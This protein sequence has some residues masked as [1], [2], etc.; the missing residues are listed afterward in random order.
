MGNYLGP[1]IRHAK[2]DTT[3]VMANRAEQ[4][5]QGHGQNAAHIGGRAHYRSLFASAVVVTSLEL[6]CRSFSA[7]SLEWL[8]LQVPGLRVWV[9]V[10]RGL[11]VCLTNLAL[12]AQ[13]FRVESALLE[14]GRQDSD[15]TRQMTDT[16]C[17]DCWEEPMII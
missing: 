11:H 5:M 8:E 15:P 7:W 4:A 10:L 16:N 17:I 13:P 9:L 14:R 6:K 3:V 1:Y 12:R 2:A